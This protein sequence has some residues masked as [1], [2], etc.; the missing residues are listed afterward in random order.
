MHSPTTPPTRIIPTAM[1]DS[2]DHGQQHIRRSVTV[3]T[4]SVLQYVYSSH[5][6]ILSKLAQNNGTAA[7]A[8]TG[9]A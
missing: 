4:A 8:E 7:T 6:C 2:S 3:V 9:W 1:C 5:S